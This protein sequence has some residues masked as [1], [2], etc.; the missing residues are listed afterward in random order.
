MV[1]MVFLSAHGRGCR[2]AAENRTCLMLHSARFFTRTRVA[3]HLM[4]YIDHK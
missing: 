2:G 4:I 3:L 1:L